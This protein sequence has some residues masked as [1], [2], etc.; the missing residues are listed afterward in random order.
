MILRFIFLLR[1]D[2][3]FRRKDSLGSTSCRPE[4]RSVAFFERLAFYGTALKVIP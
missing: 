2:E 3:S 4:N 1:C